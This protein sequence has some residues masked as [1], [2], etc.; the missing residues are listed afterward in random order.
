M[1]RGRAGGG[2]AYALTAF[3][4]FY[5]TR[6]EFRCWGSMLGPGFGVW[7]CLPDIRAHVRTL[8]Y[9][10]IF[11]TL[12]SDE[13]ACAAVVV[14]GGVRPHFYPELIPEP[15]INFYSRKSSLFLKSPGS[16]LNTHL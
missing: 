16:N 10:T 6:G 1:R 9:S 2:G 3:F 7:S 5:W 13:E 11:R 4:A 14:A 15:E 8:C 12:F